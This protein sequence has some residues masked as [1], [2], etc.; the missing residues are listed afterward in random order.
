MHLAGIMDQPRDFSLPIRHL[1]FPDNL[2]PV[3]SRTLWHCFSVSVPYHGRWVNK[4]GERQTSVIS[5]AFSSFL[6]LGCTKML[7]TRRMSPPQSLRSSQ[8]LALGRIDPSVSLTS[9][10]S[11]SQVLSEI[12]EP[13]V[14][15]QHE[16]QERYTPFLM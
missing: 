6:L 5:Q 9:T 7:S 3:A 12:L 1:F 2:I 10:C 16:N 4:S 11:P 14:E 15:Y 8:H 13:D